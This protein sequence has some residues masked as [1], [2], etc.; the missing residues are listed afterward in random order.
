MKRLLS[1]DT[2]RLAPLPPLI[3]LLF[4]SGSCALIFQMV[5]VRE[6]RLIFGASTSASAAVLAIFM[7]G[8]G[9]GNL[10]FGR[11]ADQ[12]RTPLRLYSSLEA[13]IALSA[14]ISPL[15]IDIVRF[16]YVAAGG[17]YTLG[18]PIATAFRLLGAV[19]VLAV[20]TFLMGGTLPATARAVSSNS[21]TKRSGLALLYGLNT[22]GAVAG[23]WIGNFILLEALGNRLLL[24]SACA[25]NMF[26]SMIAFAYS[27]RL[28][29]QTSEVA[30]VE[31]NQGGGSVETLSRPVRADA[32]SKVLIFSASATV[33]AV[34]FLMELV[35]YRMLAP[36][37]GGTT[38]TFGLILCT[39]LL[40]IGLG[41][42]I[43]SA[44]SRWINPSLSWLGCVCALEAVAIAIPLWYGDD[45][46]FWVLYQ[47]AQPL[48]SF[49]QQVWDWF[50]VAVVVIGP[51]AVVSGFQFPLLIACVG[52]GRQSIG[53]DV[54]R[55]FACNTAGAIFGSLAGGFVLLPMLSATGLWRACVLGLILLCLTI[56]ASI[57]RN[58]IFVE[59]RI[60]LP[61]ALGLCTLAIVCLFAEGPSSVW[62]HSGI[63]VRRAVI[64]T[65]E[66][67]QQREFANRMKRRVIW[68]AEGIESSVAIIATDSLSFVVNGKSDG[69]AVTDAGTQIGLGLLGP[70]LHDAPKLGLV[71]G[72]GTGESAGWM[73]AVT[74]I[75][76]VDVV[77][78]EP[79]VVEMASLCA[80]INHNV[81]NNPRV[82]LHFDD[83]REFLLTCRKDYDL[84][85]SEPSNPYRAGI[86]NLYTREFYQSAS[87]RLSNNG[88][89]LQWL[90]AYEVDA[91]TVEIVMTTLRSVFP[92]VQVW[93][94]KARDMVFVCGQ[95]NAFLSLTE[96]SLIDKLRQS[97][98]RDGLGDAW[99]TNDLTG[100]LAH[101]VCSER[102][103]DDLLS[104]KSLSCNSDDRNLLEYAFAKSVGKKTHFSA[105]DLTRAAIKLTD[106][107]PF[108]MS[109]PQLALIANRRLAME[110]HLGGQ[111]H[112]ISGASA[113]QSNRALAYEAYLDGR[114]EEVIQLSSQ[115]AI[116]Q[117]CPIEAA[118]FAHA[119]AELGQPVSD[120][121]MTKL[122]SH[123]E[124]ESLA[125]MAIS[126]FRA[127]DIVLA[128]QKFSEAMHC[129]RDHPWVLQPVIDGLFR[130]AIELSENSR[131]H[132]KLVFDA[133]DR[134]FAM[135][136]F[137]DN[138]VFV[139]YIVSENLG[140]TDM[141]EALQDLEPLVPWK[142]WL[143]ENRVKAYRKA[144]HPLTSLA[145]E[146]LN[147]FRLN[148][149]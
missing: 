123:C 84:I 83:A 132:A 61:L 64:S 130:I 120:Q 141:V 111:F 55:T 10:F 98:I 106:Q 144:N 14:A 116:D 126:S 80:A 59:R 66:P 87:N 15:L 70:L 127:G 36:L 38:Y 114:F 20:P 45:I 65:H 56:F 108:S 37:L 146:E 90:Q 1:M 12:T 71:I 27:N 92:K 58:K 148:D 50:Q 110:L 52:Q 101:Y 81:L 16:L 109:E 7:G 62:R 118:V 128:A 88:L 74:N 49:S 34:F 54:G 91:R 43:Y 3:C 60:H 102:T 57:V 136:R 95:G 22:I 6:L 121:W 17:Q 89:F 67:N 135:R 30:T 147:Q 142:E 72:L 73:G 32:P 149:L 139:R 63:G 131:E 53:A 35:W 11:R 122:E 133:L 19:V 29:M 26:L 9:F 112:A 41:G 107:T 28:L 68:E 140:T 23:A 79:S 47:S 33:G 117:E 42:A 103:I 145:H 113:E 119:G 76:S 46:A 104:E 78:L 4:L 44:V 96:N 2:E 100:V 138:R 125:I 134:P 5:W 48:T 69:N 51:T 13:G 8:L 40:G 21:D 97:T 77:E 82:H 105:N 99:K 115:L 94:T 143:L 137:E 93:Q 85:V 25:I 86:A 75:E 39:A 18:G 124:V 129:L 24:W 31:D